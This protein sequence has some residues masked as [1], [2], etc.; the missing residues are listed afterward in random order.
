MSTPALTRW[1]CE[2][3]TLIGDAHRPGGVTLAFTERAGGVSSGPYDSLNLGDAC[4]DEPG[5]VLENR[6]RA[7]SAMGLAGLDDRLISLKQVHGDKVL[8]IG[9][10]AL[11]L[12]EARELASEGADA[13]VCTERDVA[14]LLCSADCLLAILVAP[15]GGFAV[16]HSGWRGTAL[17]ISGKALDEL[18]ARTGARPD[19]VFCYLGPHIGAGD[20]EVSGDLADRFRESFGDEVIV[21]ERNLDLGACVRQTL[22]RRG[23]S[24][25]YIVEHEQTN[26]FASKRFFS[27]RASGGTC[28]RIGALACMPTDGSDVRPETA[29]G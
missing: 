19:E 24:S 27:Y 11:S 17:E 10:G 9:E 15:N 12:D 5:K 16:A 20:Y 4:G 8:S 7:L 23:V 14:V 1:T 26:T 25:T 3:V 6:R 28:G 18:C 13:V 22:E 29:V 21:G 2:G